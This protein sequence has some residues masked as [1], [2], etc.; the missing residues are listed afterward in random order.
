MKKIRKHIKKIIGISFLSSLIFPIS[1][2]CNLIE[3]IISFIPTEDEKQPK[4]SES[5]PIISINP[6]PIVEPHNP[7]ITPPPSNDLG[8]SHES[9]FFF[10]NILKINENEVYL[11]KS[12][13]EEE[14]NSALDYYNRTSIKNINDIKEEKDSNNRFYLQYSDPYTKI[15]FRDYSYHTD[16]DGNNRYLLGRNGLVYLAQEFKRKVPFGTEVFDLEAI[17]VNDFN[18]IS[19]KANGLYISNTKNIYI[20]G[21]IYAEKGFNLY[22]IIGGLMP[23]VFH[24]YMHHWSASY[25]ETALRTSPEKSIDETIT[26]NDKNHTPIYYNPYGES[27]ENHTHGSKQYWDS[28][29]ANNFYTLL[30]YDVDKKGYITRNDLEVFD[31]ARAW[32]PSSLPVESEKFLYRRL[33][34]KSIWD[35]A[36]SGTVSPENARAVN[37]G[38]LYY[39]P[40]G[41]FSTDYKKIKYNYS[42]TELLPREYTKYAFESYFSMNDENKAAENAQKKLPSI[43]WFGIHYFKKSN[44][45]DSIEAAYFSPSANAEDWSKVYL[46]N[47]D[48]SRRQ[49]MFKDGHTVE[50]EGNYAG[51]AINAAMTPNSV[52]DISPYRYDE[53]QRRR[54]GTNVLGNPIIRN[55]RTINELDKSKTKSRSQEFYDLFLNTMGYGKTISQIYYESD[56]KWVS[57]GSVNV[58]NTKANKVKFAGYLKDKKYEGIVVK[59]REN[60][61][62]GQSYINYYDA[63]SFFGH[64]EFDQGA[65]MVQNNEITQ[66]RQKQINNRLYPGTSKENNLNEHFYSYISNAFIN[67]EDDATIYMWDDKNQNSIVDEGELEDSEINLPTSRD[68][69]TTR[70]WNVKEPVFKK[71][72]VINENGQTKIKIV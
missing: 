9:N 64:K 34:P 39:S 10:G 1:S 69:T 48:S 6:E 26:I 38:E 25:P 66:D 19:D 60:N 28:Y 5:E 57:R 53:V 71:Y 52:F 11:P 13:T 3:N 62:I 4:D 58:D 23:T 46:N 63:F 17:N 30:N 68:I 55:V 43:S 54:F 47:F 65:K 50:T 49:F 12:Y 8:F 40:S 67:V 56:W 32:S 16:G 24:E 7:I 22:E 41:S 18:V 21:S 15:I 29:F 59:D 27:H 14:K 61:I 51:R 44:S 20:N 42:L 2:S 72:K 35:I 33:S 70:G 45:S 37:Y 36:N 31:F